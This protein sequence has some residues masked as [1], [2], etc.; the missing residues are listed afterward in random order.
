MGVFLTKKFRLVNKW[1]R[2][3]TTSTG[4]STSQNW[5]RLQNDDN[6][7]DAPLKTDKAFKGRFH[8]KSRQMHLPHKSTR[9]PWTKNDRRPMEWR[10]RWVL[11][12]L[13]WSSRII[14]YRNILRITHKNPTTHPYLPHMER[15]PK[16]SETLTP[17]LPYKEKSSLLRDLDS[18]LTT[19]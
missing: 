19:I 7:G 16:I 12:G 4:T 8:H 3:L 1:L 18:L 6:G 15:H 10:S 5:R 11:R 13:A 9:D 14:I 17:D 2:K